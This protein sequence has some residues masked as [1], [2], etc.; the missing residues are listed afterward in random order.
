MFSKQLGLMLYVDDVAAE[1]DFW[2]AVGFI[3]ESEEDTQGYGQFSMRPHPDSSL[4]F[5]V[6][7]KAFIQKVSPEVVDQVPSVLFES[8]DI[9]TL[10][11]RIASLTGTCSPI[12]EQPFK[13]FQFA[14][15]SGI[16][17]AVKGN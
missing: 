7:D 17:F 4:V 5:T 14:S 8:D 15:P 9:L 12:E 16:Y 10:H 2:Q 6:F 13:N 11:A 1:K 3:I